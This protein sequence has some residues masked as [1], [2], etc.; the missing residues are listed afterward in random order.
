MFFRSL[1]LLLSLLTA[2]P[3]LAG[4][5]PFDAKAFES[6]QSQGKSILLMVHADWCPTCRA[7]APIVEKLSKTQEFSGYEI[8]RIDYDDQED[9][10]RRFR[11]RYQSVLIVFKGK[12][13]KGRAMGMTQ[14]APIAN[15]LR[16]G[17]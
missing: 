11:A 8:F 1:F 16:K 2:L 14:E 9:A 15:L 10:V 5:K 12:Q 6:A 17:L 4:G 13:E 7:Q 3:A